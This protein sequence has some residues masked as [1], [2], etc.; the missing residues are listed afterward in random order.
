[1]ELKEYLIASNSN[2]EIIK[3]FLIENASK[4]LTEKILS[5]NKNLHDCWQ[6]IIDQAKEYLQ[7]KNGAVSDD[8]VYGWVIH[9][10]EEENAQI[11]QTQ[12][13]PIEEKTI[14]QIKREAVE[15]YKK[16]VDEKHK[17]KKENVKQGIK[18]P[19]IFDFM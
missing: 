6:F 8:K 4:T 16:S 17:T 7:D 15:E 1:M 11:D 19:S 2:E 18:Q 12:R 3:K 9:Y 13:L 14:E 10:F 5:G